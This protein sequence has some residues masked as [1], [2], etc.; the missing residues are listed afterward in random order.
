MGDWETSRP[1]FLN[2]ESRKK[3]TKRGDYGASGGPAGARIWVRKVRF[4]LGK[5]RWDSGDNL[6]MILTGGYALY[7]RR[8][9]ERACVALLGLRLREF[10][11]LPAYS[12]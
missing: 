7:Q 2:H 6:D 8:L 3:S 12:G 1:L 10:E 4:P 11:A 5:P 9:W